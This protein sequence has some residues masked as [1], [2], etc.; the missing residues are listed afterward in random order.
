M[1]HRRARSTATVT[2]SHGN[3]V[4]GDSVGFSASDVGVH[5]GSVTD[6][7]D[8]TY[9]ATV[10]SSTTVHA[11][12]ITATDSSPAPSVAGQTTL[13][14]TPGPATGVAVGLSP[15]SIVANGA[16]TSTVT[17]TVT[18]AQGHL[19]SGESVSFSSSDAGATIG[20]VSDHGDG[21]YTA[22]VTSS[23]T[24]HAITITA[25]D[26][27][28]AP[29][30]AGHT[31]LTQTPGPA[32]GVAVGLSPGSIV[33]NGASTSTVT[34]TV[35]DSHGNPVA[36]DSVGFSASDVGVHFGSVT[37]HGDGT[38]TATVTSSTTVHAI[39]ITATDSSPAPSVAG[40]T[41]LMQTPGPAT[42]V[43]VGLSPG[44]IVANG[45]STSTVTTA[46]VTDAQGHLLSGESVSFSSSDAGA[47]IGLVSDHGDGTYTATVTSSTTAHAI[48]ITATDSSVAPSVAGH[49]TLTQTPGPA[50]GVAVGLSPGSIVANGAS[51]S[52]VTATVT[53]SHGNPVAG[54][55]VGFSASDVGVHF[56]SVTDHGDGTYTATV[57]SSTTVHA[58]TITATDSSP[59]PSVAGQTTLMQTPGPATGVDPGPNPTPGP[60]TN[61]GP[62]AGPTPDPAT[63]VTG[64]SGAEIRRL[65]LRILVPR[66]KAARIAELSRRHGYSFAFDS[67]TAGRLSVSWYRVSRGAHVTKAKPKPVLVARAAVLLSKA[68]RARIKIALTSNGTRLLRH[69]AKLQLT[70]KGAFT[71]AG[72]Q[73]VS[74][75]KT[76]SV[77]R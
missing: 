49:T 63:S 70:A 45:A 25:T 14:Q 41:T 72:A 60:T 44:S 66:G 38:Y 37:D 73:Q 31:T 43:A 21:T 24:A 56:G 71:P 64:P 30:V 20:L 76:F 53:D 18:D 57:T 22:T 26:S 6:H 62:S 65:L 7:G 8:G 36:G 46:T 77:S 15:G 16:S 75:T 74:A 17:A 13:M 35:T 28:V 55:S 1:A 29:S 68:G 48:T 32:T 33:A 52:T 3:P 61:P 59:A 10:T 51:T 4:A 69:A 9:T 50:T 5:F 42:G 40:Q 67:P 19:L 12:T 39:T 11:I 58:I 27:S 47:T 34:A 54:D 2:D 23:T